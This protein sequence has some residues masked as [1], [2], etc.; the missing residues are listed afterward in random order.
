MKKKTHSGYSYNNQC[1]LSY[2]VIF[3]DEE[4]EGQEDEDEDK[5]KD[6]EED[7]EGEGEGEEEGEFEGVV[8]GHFEEEVHIFTEQSTRQNFKNIPTCNKLKK[9][10]KTK[11]NIKNIEMSKEKKVQMNESNDCIHHDCGFVHYRMYPQNKFCCFDIHWNYQEITD[12]HMTALCKQLTD[13]ISQVCSQQQQ[14]ALKQVALPNKASIK[15]V[16]VSFH[17]SSNQIT[18]KGLRILLKN[19]DHFCCQK[20]DFSRNFLGDNGYLFFFFFKQ[21]IIIIIIMKVAKQRIPPNELSLSYNNIGWNGFKNIMDGIKSRE[22]SS[23]LK[24]KYPIIPYTTYYL[25]KAA[26]LWLILDNN[27]IPVEQALSYCETEGI[28]YCFAENYIEVMFPNAQSHNNNNNDNNNS[29]NNNDDIHDYST[30][31]TICC[32]SRA[33][34]PKQEMA[35]YYR[36]CYKDIHTI[37]SQTKRTFKNEGLD[38]PVKML[39]KQYG[40]F[41]YDEDQAAFIDNDLIKVHPT[42][43]IPKTWHFDLPMVHLYQFRSQF[44]ADSNYSSHDYSHTTAIANQNHT[45]AI[46]NINEDEYEDE[47]EEEQEQE[48]EDNND[49]GD[50]GNENNHQHKHENGNVN[51]NANAS[52]NKIEDANESTIFQASETE[53]INHFSE[54]PFVDNL[55]HKVEP[56]F[57]DKKEQEHEP[58]QGQQQQEQEKTEKKEEEEEEEE[59][60]DKKENDGD[61]ND[62]DDDG[63][64]ENEEDKNKDNADNTKDAE[65]KTL[66]ANDKT[67][68]EQNTEEKKE[69]KEET[70]KS[71]TEVTYAKQQEAD[72]LEMK[73]PKYK[74]ESP[75]NDVV[76]N[77]PD[78]RNTQLPSK[79]H[80]ES[81]SEPQAQAQAQ[82]QVQAQPQAQTQT[83]INNIKIEDET[84]QKTHQEKVISDNDS[85]LYLIC[86]TNVLI[87][88]VR[89]PPE[90]RRLEWESATKNH[91]FL[92][93]ILRHKTMRTKKKPSDIH[94]F[95]KMLRTQIFPQLKTDLDSTQIQQLFYDFVNQ[96]KKNPVPT[97]D[98]N[99]IFFAIERAMGKFL[100][101]DIIHPLGITVSSKEMT[102]YVKEARKFK[103]IAVNLQQFENSSVFHFDRLI[104]KAEKKMFGFGMP[105]ARDK[106]LLIVPYTVT[107]ELEYIK[108]NNKRATR[109]IMCAQQL[110]RHSGI[111]D[112]ASQLKILQ[113]LS[114]QQNEVCFFFF[115]CVYNKF[116]L[117]I[118]ENYGLFIL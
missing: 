46:T 15:W 6:E 36:Q 53:Q 29:N 35:E 17:L 20:L 81:H 88:M 114:M 50:N 105:N 47:Y 51:A 93:E 68:M 52:V 22:T 83:K 61:D 58:P 112:K 40:F 78:I 18:S 102:Q 28:R 45:G 44:T 71:E 2:L 14:G 85:C 117:F 75:D 104:E 73:V 115:L 91:Q 77:P 109:A 65:N 39:R 37:L 33:C 96:S 13:Q 23:E 11:Q 5:D 38:L 43:P 21:I 82:A 108:R 34:I 66:D 94:A 42:F 113:K 111:F 60:K 1:Q 56:L 118:Y 110:T 97:V 86:D 59:E 41:D 32:H 80:S 49:Y 74:Q 87:Q 103:G 25:Q 9:K 16:V 79:P 101:D 89:L 12:M 70:I 24:L 69:E 48:Q 54:R 100:L 19:I 72:E 31:S 90:E 8:E 106:T 27:N 3:E 99:V 30:D 26:P 116:H 63:S 62:N 95:E 10:N 7:E 107:Q 55:D 4:E 98:N 76:P 64:D 84:T 57:Q 67:D 92:L